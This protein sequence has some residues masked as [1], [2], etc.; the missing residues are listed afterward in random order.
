[1]SIFRDSQTYVVVHGGQLEPGAQAGH[2]PTSVSWQSLRA[3]Q[4]ATSRPLHESA[5]GRETHSCCVWQG[6]QFEPGAHAG[7]AVTS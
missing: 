3:A 6:G 7:H 2:T 1:M 5:M 4:A